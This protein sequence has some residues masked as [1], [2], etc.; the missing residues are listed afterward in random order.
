[1]I[2]HAIGLQRTG[3]NYVTELVRLNLTRNVIGT[4]DRSICWKH[5]LPID[6]TPAGVTAAEAVL[7]RPDA[8]ICL[9]AKHPLHWMASVT[10][11]DPQDLFMKRKVLLVDGA[12]DVAATARFYGRFYRMWLDLLRHRGGF[13]IVRYEDALRDPR[14]ALAPVAEALGAVGV[15][16]HISLPER[17]PYSRTVPEERKAAYLAGE[18]GLGGETGLTVEAN[19][20][21][22]VLGELGYAR[23]PA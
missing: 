6:K 22:W 5:A 3:T 4:G 2:V 16:D 23:M 21:S 19:L 13:A 1:M 7:G 12:P 11:R 8:L 9:V 15:P 20:D 14:S 18:H 10:L 17:V